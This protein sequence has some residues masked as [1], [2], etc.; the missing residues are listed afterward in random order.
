MDDYSPRQVFIFSI[1]FFDTLLQVEKGAEYDQPKEGSPKKNQPQNSHQ[2][3]ASASRV[4]KLSQQCETHE[5]A[6]STQCI[7]ANPFHKEKLELAIHNLFHELCR[8]CLQLL[9]HL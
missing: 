3:I 6:A 4:A 8:I 2:P 1:I 9:N 7:V 5:R